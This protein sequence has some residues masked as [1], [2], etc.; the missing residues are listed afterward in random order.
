MIATTP[1]ITIQMAPMRAPITPPPQY[2]SYPD[3]TVEA[4]ARNAAYAIPPS[5]KRIPTMMA[6]SFARCSIDL[7]DCTS[8]GSAAIG[9][10]IEYAIGAPMELLAPIGAP[11]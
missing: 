8:G 1:P 5:R 10:G 7:I 9:G 6:S 11:S 2:A 3:Q 4:K